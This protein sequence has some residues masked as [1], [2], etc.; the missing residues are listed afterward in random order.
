MKLAIV[1][2]RWWNDYKSFRNQVFNTGL[3]VSDSV[4]EIV[5]GGARGVDYLAYV[6]SEE[7]NLQYIEFPPSKSSGSFTEACH[8]RNQLIVDVSDHILAFPSKESKGTYDTIRRARVADK[9][10]TIINIWE[11]K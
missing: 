9:P 11:I 3:L 10:V 5:S 4:I 2:S 1:G 8:I 7:L 6:L